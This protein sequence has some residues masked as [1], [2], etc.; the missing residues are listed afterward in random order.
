MEVTLAGFI[1]TYSIS[2]F[3]SRGTFLNDDF[4]L[5]RYQ[6]SDSI[7]WNDDQVGSKIDKYGLQ[8]MNDNYHFLETVPIDYVRHRFWVSKYFPIYK[9]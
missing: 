6:E 8:K 5:A 9:L 4:M 3:I 2:N 7:W 1:Y